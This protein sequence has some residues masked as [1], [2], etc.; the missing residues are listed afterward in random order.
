[1]WAFFFSYLFLFPFLLCFLVEGVIY[2]VRSLSGRQ[3][4]RRGVITSWVYSKERGG[5]HVWWALSKETEDQWS[6]P[7]STN[8]FTIITS[9]SSEEWTQYELGLHRGIVGFVGVFYVWESVCL[10]FCQ[11][12]EAVQHMKCL[13][14][15]TG[16]HTMMKCVDSL[17]VT[18][19]GTHETTTTSCWPNNTV[20]LHSHF[21][22][23]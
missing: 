1:M 7:R 5:F 12:V 8:C 19:W 23:C 14:W 2:C 18:Q 15:L 21:Y 13:H 16:R 3:H 11:M 4:G 9:T 6:L 22:L 17:K 10:Y 20:F